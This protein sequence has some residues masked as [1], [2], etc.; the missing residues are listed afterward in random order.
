M[1][2]VSGCFGHGPPAPRAAAP[3][4]RALNPRGAAST[5]SPSRGFPVFAPPPAVTT[6]C[7]KT[8][9]N[10]CIRWQ[11]LGT[12]AGGRA[13]GGGWGQL[14]FLLLAPTSSGCS[15]TGTPAGSVCVL[16]G[17]VD[18]SQCWSPCAGHLWVLVLSFKG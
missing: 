17:S 4:D 11:L 1:P 14:C 13:W 2:W 15:G 12:V 5:V 10:F 8:H 16:G 9:G 6:G 3:P 7:Y 18:M